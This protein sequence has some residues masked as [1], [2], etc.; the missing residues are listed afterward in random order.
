MLH[1]GGELGRAL[2]RVGDIMHTGVELPLVK[3][4]AAMREVLI[5]MTGKHFGCAGVLDQDGR[6]IGIITDGDLRRNMDNGIL[7]L[8]AE[9]VMTKKPLTICKG[10]LAAEAVGV[11]NARDNPVTC[12]F[13]V[14]DEAKDDEAPRPIGIVH[15]HDC[16]RAGVS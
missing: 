9:A 10:A 16:L 5:E 14:A 11:M 7:E 6:L 1:P 13:V 12:L 8:A 15:M 4:A 2:I 3:R